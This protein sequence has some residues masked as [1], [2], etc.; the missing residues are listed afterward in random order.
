MG[1]PGGRAAV[2]ESEMRRPILLSRRRW[3]L[4]PSAYRWT[5]SPG[6]RARSFFACSEKSRRKR[7]AWTSSSTPRE[8]ERVRH[9]DELHDPWLG[10]LGWRS[11]ARTR[12]GRLRSEQ[13]QEPP[14][15][16]VALG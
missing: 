1:L 4:R 9:D 13:S 7:P 15:A 11:A 12:L 3:W 16:H 6:R 8:L 5:R 10:L 2:G 14:P